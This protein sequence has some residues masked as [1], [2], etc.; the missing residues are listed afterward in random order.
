MSSVKHITDEVENGSVSITAQ[1][2]A[3][4]ALWLAVAAWLW[5]TRVPGG[6][7][8]PHLDSADFFPADRL[9]RADRYATGNRALWAATLAV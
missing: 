6:L 8:L 7:E 9:A 2:L 3:E 4:R 1:K 5:R